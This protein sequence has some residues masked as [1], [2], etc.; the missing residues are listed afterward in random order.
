MSPKDDGESKKS[1]LMSPRARVASIHDQV[2]AYSATETNTRSK[3]DS[4]GATFTISGTKGE[5]KGLV[6]Q[7]YVSELLR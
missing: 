5:A 1:L 7:Y 3:L 4:A 2:M 6:Y